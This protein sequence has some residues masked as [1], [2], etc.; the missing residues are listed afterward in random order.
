MSLK[1]KPTPKD[2][3]ISVPLRLPVRYGE[4]IRTVQ[5]LMLEDRSYRGNISHQSAVRYALDKVAGEATG[6]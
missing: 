4:T 1:K 2:N 3:R 6:G 5:K